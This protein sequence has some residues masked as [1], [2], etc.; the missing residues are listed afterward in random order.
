MEG[1]F[2]PKPEDSH[3][4]RHA[5]KRKHCVGLRF[6]PCEA[7]RGS[8]HW[9][10]RGLPRTGQQQGNSRLTP[11]NQISPNAVAIQRRW[12]SDTGLPAQPSSGIIR[13]PQ[14]VCRDVHDR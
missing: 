13:A 1:T 9:R 8:S 11:R 10:W 3:G 12:T 2:G 5:R 7:C 6:P 14:M 4:R